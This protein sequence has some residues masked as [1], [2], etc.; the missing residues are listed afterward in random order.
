[1]LRN[2]KYWT[3]S[4]F[5]VS[6]HLS[7]KV[8]LN[9]LF[10]DEIEI[11]T[12][13]KWGIN[14]YKIWIYTSRPWVPSFKWG[15]CKLYTKL[16]LTCSKRLSNILYRPRVAHKQNGVCPKWIGEPHWATM[17][18][19]WQLDVRFKKLSKQNTKNRAIMLNLWQ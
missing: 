1:M 13:R 2:W 8:Q 3:N 7:L 19:L 10:I 15:I 4:S 12:Q 16:G 6:K 5:V 14:E 9:Q 11:K 18:N 17:L